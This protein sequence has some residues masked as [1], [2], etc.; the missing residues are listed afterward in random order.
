MPSK[1][2]NLKILS[3]NKAGIFFAAFFLFFLCLVTYGNI[4]THQFMDDDHA[5]T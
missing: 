1:L 2:R 4:L 5:Y 3:N